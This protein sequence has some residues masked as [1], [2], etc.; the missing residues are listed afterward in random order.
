VFGQELQPQPL[1]LRPVDQWEDSGIGEAYGLDEL[2]AD[3]I[4][5]A[6]DV[7]ADQ[8]VLVGFS[9]SGKFAQYVSARYPEPVLGQFSSAA[10]PRASF[11]SR[12]SCSEAVTS[13]SFTPAPVPTLGVGGA[14]DP[15]S[16]RICC[17]PASSAQSPEPG[18]SFSKPTTR[19][20]ATFPGSSR[21]S[22]RPS[23]RRWPIRGGSCST[24]RSANRLSVEAAPITV[25][26]QR[27]VG[28]TRT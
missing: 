15:V 24:P 27:A 19:S 2:A 28:V 26:A 18:S 21:H 4:A 7:G 12:P 23:W 3:V 16:R 20:R 1:G 22:P 25:I 17:A 11:R 14:H 9:M 13:T 8:L 10:V 5:V 6:D